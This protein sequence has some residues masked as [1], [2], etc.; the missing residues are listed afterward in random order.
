MEEK[1]PRLE[2]TEAAPGDSGNS[3][4]STGINGPDGVG[5]N[6]SGGVYGASMAANR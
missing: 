2:M 4:R 1:S 5:V 3:C 6:R